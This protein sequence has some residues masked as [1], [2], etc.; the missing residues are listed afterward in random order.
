M[1]DFLFPT[2]KKQHNNVKIQ[3]DEIF[4]FRFDEIVCKNSDLKT[5]IYNKREFQ[6]ENGLW[7]FEVEF[8]GSMR[9]AKNCVEEIKRLIVEHFWVQSFYAY[10]VGECI[11][12]KRDNEYRIRVIYAVGERIPLLRA[13]EEKNQ[14]LK[15]MKERKKAENVMRLEKS[16]GSVSLGKDD[17]ATKQRR[18]EGEGVRS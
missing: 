18:S 14:R 8:F 4:A 6:L 17:E 10:C 7:G 13:Y 2:A 1:L 12:L 15:D 9:S 16:I 3:I 5:S 11:D